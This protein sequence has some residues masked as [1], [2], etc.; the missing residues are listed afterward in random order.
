M[1]DKLRFDPAAFTMQEVEV[2]G[3]KV[4]YKEYKSICYC[5]NPVDDDYESL[6]IRVPVS[7]DGKAIDCTDSPV[8][9]AVNVAGYTATANK[10]VHAMFGHDDPCLLYTSPSP[11]D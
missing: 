2:E 4:A 8:L 9:F 1:S 6:D 7:V 3:K 11:R 10:G 5:T